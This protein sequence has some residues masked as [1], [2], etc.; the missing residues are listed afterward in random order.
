[1]VGLV[2]RVG[3]PLWVAVGA[4]RATGARGR[5]VAIVQI[6]QENSLARHTPVPLTSRHATTLL[7]SSFLSSL[8]HGTAIRE[9]SMFLAHFNAID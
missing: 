4:A 3:C 1:M 6:S 2:C 7:R 9:A 5:R 8:P